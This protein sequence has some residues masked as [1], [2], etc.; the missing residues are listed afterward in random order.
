MTAHGR[1]DRLLRY[2]PVSGNEA[3]SY[4]FTAGFAQFAPEMERAAALIVV[5]WLTL[6][7]PSAVLA[8]PHCSLAIRQRRAV[9]PIR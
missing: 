9:H 4:D 2:Y 6:I 8:F 7:V 5:S 3:D 1:C